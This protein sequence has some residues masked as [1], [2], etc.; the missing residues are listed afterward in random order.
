MAKKVTNIH[1]PR[2]V[3]SKSTAFT[4][5]T[6]ILSLVALSACRSPYLRSIDAQGNVVKGPLSNAIV[7]FDYNEDG[8]INEFEPFTRTGEDGSFFLSGKNG[9]SF[10]VLTDETTV[11]ASSGE[12]LANVVL[13]APIGSSIISPTTTIMDETGLNAEEVGIIL[14]LPSGIDPTQFNPFG[15]NVD[16]EQALAVEKV[17]HQVMNTVTALSS[18]VEGAGGDIKNS[19]KIAL[20]SVV[21]VVMVRV[22]STVSFK[23]V[24]LA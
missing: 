9:Y 4:A 11:D 2:L 19:F 21:D 1:L 13:S 17:A 16:P 15:D 3:F 24:E 5:S 10:T 18:A 23:T 22:G 20:D 7:F 12:I 6:S 14:G 8:V